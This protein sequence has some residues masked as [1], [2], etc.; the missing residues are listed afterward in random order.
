M[1]VLGVDA[2]TVA[3]RPTERPGEELQKLSYDYLVLAMGAHLA[4]D[5]IEGFAAH[6]HTVSDLFHGQRLREPLFEGGYKGGPDTIGSARFHQGDGAE[7]LQPY[8]GGS[9]PYAKAACE[10]PVREMTTVMASYLKMEANSSPSR[11]TVF[12]PEES[13]AADAGENNIKA[14]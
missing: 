6:G 8:P 9:I 14:S 5:R 10:G 1:L 12:T 13:I 7:G 3:F 4:Y 11:I 2:K